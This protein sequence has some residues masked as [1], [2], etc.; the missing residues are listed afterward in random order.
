MARRG[1]GAE[2]AESLATRGPSVLGPGGVALGRAVARAGGMALTGRIDGPR[3]AAVMFP[4][5]GAA[6]MLQDHA[7]SD[8]TVEGASQTVALRI[9]VALLLAGAAWLLAGLLVPTFLA[10]ILAIAL[11]PVA[12]RLERARVPSF[13]WLVRSAPSPWRGA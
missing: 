6:A 5:K 1:P 7:P 12:A 13:S 4:R 2:E 8:A 9:L 10:A 3:R 11:S